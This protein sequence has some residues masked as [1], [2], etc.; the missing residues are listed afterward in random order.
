RN[1][2][3]TVVAGARIQTLAPKV[4]R[5]CPDPFLGSRANVW[6]A[7]GPRAE[8]K[9][10]SSPFA[11]ARTDPEEKFELL[12]SGNAII[13]I[14]LVTADGYAP[15]LE[16]IDAGKPLD[17]GLEEGRDLS[18]QLL[19]AEDDKPVEEAEVTLVPLYLCGP[20]VNAFGEDL[21]Q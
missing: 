17:I 11:V 10:E 12:N 9:S 3:G 5:L 6:I 20:V 18:I 14:S 21:V 13:G 16:V 2:G 19:S 4:A 1:A 15:H 8:K 7:A